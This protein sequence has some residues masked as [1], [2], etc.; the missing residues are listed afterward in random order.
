MFTCTVVV[1]KLQVWDTSKFRNY[2][3]I[4]KLIFINL[5]KSA[6]FPFQTSE[7]NLKASNNQL[8]KH[9]KVQQ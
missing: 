7:N 5:L 3:P 2:D 9:I 8:K 1:R 4:I 6:A